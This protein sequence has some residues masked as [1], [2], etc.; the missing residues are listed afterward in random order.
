MKRR[1]SCWI[2]SLLV[3]L[4][5][6]LSIAVPLEPI[7]LDGPRFS[8]YGCSPR[9]WS[10]LTLSEKAALTT[11]PLLRRRY[12]RSVPWRPPFPRVV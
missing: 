10:R 11:A 1:A 7:V 12:F 9:P 2:V 3:A 4:P 5:P 6:L 8:P